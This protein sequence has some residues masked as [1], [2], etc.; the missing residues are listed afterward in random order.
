MLGKLGNLSD[1]K[2]QS[3]IYDVWS[4]F[5][6]SQIE[7][8]RNEPRPDTINSASTFP[9]HKRGKL[10]QEYDQIFYIFTAIIHLKYQSLTDP[11]G[12]PKIVSAF[13]QILFIFTQF[14][15]K[16]YQNNRLARLPLVLASASILEILDN[17][18]LR[19]DLK[20]YAVQTTH[21][22]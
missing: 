14:A 22:P 6:L 16:F 20:V 18:V 3:P 17:I 15:G 13:D 9:A 19:P 4:G 7:K 11:R 1:R 8:K 5:G 10:N 12:T 21:I 2:M